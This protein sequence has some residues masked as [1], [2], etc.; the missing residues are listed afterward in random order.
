M[1]HCT[2]ERC[3]CVGVP[4]NTMKVFCEHWNAEQAPHSVHL[5]SIAMWSS[6]PADIQDRCLRKLL[7]T[8]PARMVHEWRDQAARGM[9]IGSDDVRFHF[10]AG[11]WVRNLLRGVVPDHELP[12]KRED[13]L[14]EPTQWDEYYYGALHALVTGEMHAAILALVPRGQ[15]APT[16][17]E[18]FKTGVGRWLRRN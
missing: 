18:R 1:G 17:W 7:A 10:A 4:R 2:Q 16:R 11:M 6:L 9:A 12:F 13:G 15:A 8:V 14:L 5:D 3:E